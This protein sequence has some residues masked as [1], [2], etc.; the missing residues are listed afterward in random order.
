[1]TC[2]EV[3]LYEL[4]IDLDLVVFANDGEQLNG[5]KLS[6]DSEALHKMS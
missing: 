1:M 6:Q 2:I 3:F 5:N 4:K